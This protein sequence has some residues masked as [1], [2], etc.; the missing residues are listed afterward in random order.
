[1]LFHILKSTDWA[2]AKEQGKYAPASLEAEGFIHL[3]EEQQVAGTV[4]RF[5][6]GQ[7]DLLLLEIDPA[8]IRTSLQYDQVGDHGV[9]PHLYEALNIEAVVKVWLLDDF[10]DRENL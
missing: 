10:L 6:Q 9:F 2:T 5:Y 3:S 4:E 1:M 7:S 8:R